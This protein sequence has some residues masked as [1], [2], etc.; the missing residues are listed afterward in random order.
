MEL[1]EQAMSLDHPLALVHLGMHYERGIGVTQDYTKA[2]ELYQ[3]LLCHPRSAG[4]DAIQYVHKALSRFD[5]SGL[6]GLEQSNKLAT[7]YSVFSESNP[8]S[9][10]ELENLEQWW[11]TTGQ[12]LPDF[13]AR[14]EDHDE[15][16]AQEAG[17]CIRADS[18]VDGGVQVHGL[19]LPVPPMTHSILRSDLVKFWTPSP[20][21]ILVFDNPQIPRQI[22]VS[23]IRGK[24]LEM[25]TIS[26]E[27]LVQMDNE[28]RQPSRV[29]MVKSRT[30][31]WKMHAS[32]QLSLYRESPDQKT[33]NMHTSLMSTIRTMREAAT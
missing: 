4:E 12:H 14:W 19:L 23:T 28:R 29:R 10:V 1:Y 18:K 17:T 11:E 22:L 30:K 7:K 16:T 8:E 26:E 27:T 9:A 13:R 25:W 15:I 24:T 33:V 20:S 31:L 21:D 32:R 5:K 3:R 2:V 6:G